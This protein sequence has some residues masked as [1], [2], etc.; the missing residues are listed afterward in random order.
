MPGPV[1][2]ALPTT[3]SAR[4][5]RADADTRRLAAAAERALAVRRDGG[6][7]VVEGLVHS[8]G[9]SNIN[10]RIRLLRSWEMY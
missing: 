8:Q 2:G 5:L 1:P 9:H 10:G 4:Q 7:G 6:A 3:S